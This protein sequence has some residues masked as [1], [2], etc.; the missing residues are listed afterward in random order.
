MEEKVLI[1]TFAN[2]LG[3]KWSIIV[4][5]PEVDLEES[6]IV[7]VMDLILAKKIFA[8]K[9]Y[10][11]AATVDAKIVEKSTIKFDLEV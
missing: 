11:M 9:G 8:P 1:M 6:A 4:D 5:D 7:T 3:N 2:T 10:E